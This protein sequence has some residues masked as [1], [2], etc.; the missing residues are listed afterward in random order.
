[1][2]YDYSSWLLGFNGMTYTCNLETQQNECEVCMYMYMLCT[3]VLQVNISTIAGSRHVGPI[4][5]RVED[6]GKKLA[7]FAETLV[8]WGYNI[9]IQ[10]L[11][12]H[13][14]IKS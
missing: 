1:M 9:I 3:R 13:C 2:D 5:P 8:S 11:A 6:W 12:F 7:L 10:P 14:K 4:R